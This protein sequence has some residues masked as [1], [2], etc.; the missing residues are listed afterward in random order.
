MEFVSKKIKEGIIIEQQTFPNGEQTAKISLRN[1]SVGKRF[2]NFLMDEVMLYIVSF[3]IGFLIDLFIFF[4]LGSDFVGN[5]WFNFF[6]GLCITF[7]YYFIF[8]TSLQ[9]TPAKFITG[10]KVVM[11]DGSKPGAG[12]IAKRSIIRL[13]PFE[14][15]SIYTGDQIENKGTWWHDRWSGTRVV[16]K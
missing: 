14:V 16:R 10:T 15:I 6:L 12:T 11:E 4:F 2:L 13:V 1:A 7:L 8:E 5:F 3:I 9:R